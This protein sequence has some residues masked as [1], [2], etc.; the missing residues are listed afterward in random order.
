MDFMAMQQFMAF[1]QQQMEAQQEHEDWTRKRRR[2]RATQPPSFMGGYV[3]LLTQGIE[4]LVTQIDR[5]KVKKDHRELMD[6]IER[7]QL[8][9]ARIA[10]HMHNQQMQAAA[11]QAKLRQKPAIRRVLQPS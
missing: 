2:A 8:E 6:G 9:Q 10:Q 4:N 11:R 7:I 3:P 1:Q 5:Q